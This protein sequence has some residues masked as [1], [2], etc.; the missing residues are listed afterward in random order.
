VFLATTMAYDGDAFGD[1]AG[2]SL[3]AKLLGAT[4]TG[5]GRNRAIADLIA[6]ATEPRAQLIHL[7]MILAVYEAKSSREDWR[8]LNPRTQRYLRQL[9]AIGYRLSPVETRATGATPEP[10]GTEN[11]PDTETQH[12]ADDVAE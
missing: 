8:T 5:F 1:V 11:P 3:A 9:A 7:L 4:T 2:N 6:K 12:A 10:T